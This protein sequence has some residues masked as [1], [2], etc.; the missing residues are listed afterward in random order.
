M[1]HGR[2]RARA[3][4][5]RAFE[6]VL[7]AF[8]FIAAA[9]SAQSLVARHRRRGYDRVLFSRA[10]T[11]APILHA[12]LRDWRGLAA[13]CSRIGGGRGVRGRGAPGV[14]DRRRGAYVALAWLTI[15]G[16]AFLLSTL[17]VFHTPLVVL[18]VGADL[19][20]DRYATALRAAGA[21]QP[22]GRRGAVSAAAGPRRRDAQRAVRARL[23]VDPRTLVWPVAFGVVCLAAALLLLRRRPFGS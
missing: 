16:L 17:T 10:L 23:V 18:L 22:G 6:L 12:G 21:G 5:Q 19:A 4:L 2:R 20:L 7:A 13:R 11:P 3:Q 8:A 14:G 15:G 1:R 9:L